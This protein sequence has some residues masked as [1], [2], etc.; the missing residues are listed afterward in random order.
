MGSEVVGRLRPTALLLTADTIR[1]ET[2]D[3]R[4]FGKAIDA[5]TPRCVGP[6]AHAKPIS[7]YE[8]AVNVLCWIHRGNNRTREFLRSTITRIG[9]NSTLAR[10]LGPRQMDATSASEPGYS[11][12]GGSSRVGTRRA[13]EVRQYRMPP[14]SPKPGAGG[15][16]VADA[17]LEPKVGV[18]TYHNASIITLPE[19]DD[20]EDADGD[21]D[22]ANHVHMSI[23]AYADVVN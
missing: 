17:F 20:D 23:Q 22:E 8:Q 5:L 9:T 2:E 6:W 7:T 18:Q 10:A 12:V 15:T 3:R 14:Q 21:D 16:A 13:T 4:V 11:E 1:E 19:D